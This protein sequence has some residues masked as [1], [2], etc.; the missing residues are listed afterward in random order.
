MKKRKIA[1]TVR[2]CKLVKWLV[3]EWEQLFPKQPMREISKSQATIGGLHFDK[4]GV[5]KRF[6]VLQL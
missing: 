5:D 6:E 3:V 1:G 4:N 2:E